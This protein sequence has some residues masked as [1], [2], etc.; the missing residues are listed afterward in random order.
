MQFGKEPYFSFISD[1]D[2]LLRM[3]Y[4]ELTLDKHLV[5]LAPMHERYAKLE[6]AGK[7]EVYTARHDGALVGYS[8]FVVDR[9]I[10]YRDL[11]VASN[12]VLYLHPEYRR[13][14]AG[15]KLIR[16]S[17]EMLAERGV[18]KVFWHIK[19]NRE[20]GDKK[21]FRAIMHRMGYGDE[22]VV[23]GKILKRG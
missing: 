23:V 5:Q 16:Y 1:A 7:L 17:E 14:M 20:P 9:H 22:E 11:L 21:D 19:F 2:D 4:Q 10:H 15:I 3:H 18:D 8:L 13:G 12:D 6:A